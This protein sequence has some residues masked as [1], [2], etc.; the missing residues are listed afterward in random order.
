MYYEPF[1]Q[2]MRQTLLGNLCAINNDHGCDDYI[3]V[4]HGNP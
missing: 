3:H 4:P 2:M 1:Y